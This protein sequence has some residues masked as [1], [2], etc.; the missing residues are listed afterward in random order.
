M[1]R[2]TGMA[3]SRNAARFGDTSASRRLDVLQQDA[4]IPARSQAA[5]GACT[6]HRKLCILYP[7]ESKH[8]MYANHAAF[9]KFSQ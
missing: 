7:E 6:S 4:A 5:G 3:V 9:L 1:V 8:H 2:G